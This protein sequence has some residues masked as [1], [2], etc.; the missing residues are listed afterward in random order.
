MLYQKVSL[1]GNIAPYGYKRVKLSNSKGYSL[2][3]DE[4]EANIVS[5][6]YRLYAY[7]NKS[8][9]GIARQLNEIF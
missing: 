8:I 7:E 9:N 1:F 3:V 5:E 6:I 4:K 2:E